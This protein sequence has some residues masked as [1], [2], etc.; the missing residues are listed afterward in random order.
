MFRQP[1]FSPARTALHAG[2]LMARITSSDPNPSPRTPSPL[3]LMMAII[4]H[5][6]RTRRHTLEIYWDC[7]ESL[8][9]LI[10][11]F[12]NHDLCSIGNVLIFKGIP[13]RGPSLPSF[14]PGGMREEMGE[15]EIK[16]CGCSRQ[17]ALECPSVRQRHPGPGPGPWGRGA[18]KAK[19]RPHGSV[20][21]TCSFNFAIFPFEN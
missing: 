15:Q 9:N 13:A 7:L 6:H 1:A 5:T 10:M 4:C 3:A 8:R 2:N 11:G 21:K 18:A 16:A 17:R 12:I 19:A 14:R 20:Q